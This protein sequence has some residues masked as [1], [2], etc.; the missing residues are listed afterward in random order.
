ML[1][2]IPTSGCITNLEIAFHCKHNQLYVRFYR[3]D[4]RAV[5]NAITKLHRKA[6]R[7]A[8][9]S[10]GSSSSLR[11]QS[12]VHSYSRNARAARSSSQPMS[13]PVMSITTTARRG[14]SGHHSVLGYVNSLFY[15]NFFKGP[16]S[17]LTSRVFTLFECSF[18]R[19]Y[20]QTTDQRNSGHRT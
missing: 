10:P 16:S 12:P 8:W 9:I 20:I 6:K 7:L 14:A 18:V 5:F 4:T 1:Q 19:R 13:L 17:V 2:S 15:T 11:L 3:S